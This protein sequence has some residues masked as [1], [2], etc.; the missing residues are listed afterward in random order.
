MKQVFLLV[1]SAFAATSLGAAEVVL[2][3]PET[4]WRTFLVVGP[5]V[6]WQN[7]DQN[8]WPSKGGG[9]LRW[10]RPGLNN[11]PLDPATADLD[12]AGFSPRPSADWVRPDADVSAWTRYLLSDL[13]GALGFYGWSEAS[14]QPA[15]LCLRTRFG[16]A[17]PAKAADLEVTVT[18]LGGAVVYVNGREVGRGFM[19]EGTLH[20]LTPATDLPIESYTLADGKTPLNP[21][22]HVQTEKARFEKRIRRFRLRV[23]PA[24]LVKGRNVLAVG[25]HRAAVAGPQKDSRFEDLTHLSVHEVQLTSASGA[26]VIPYDQATAGTWAWSANPEQQV[27]D[28]P[29]KMPF[30]RGAVRNQPVRGIPHGNPFDPVL[31]IRMAVPRNGVGSGQTVLTDKAGLRGVAARMG[32]LKGPQGEL[33]ADA[34][35]IRYAV[36]TP[37]MHFCDRLTSSPPEGAKTVPVWT[38]VHVH[39]PDSVAGYYKVKPWSAEH[40]RLMEPAFRMVGQLGN[41]VL[42]V[43]VI[44]GNMSPPQLNNRP[45]VKLAEWQ[46]LVRWVKQGDSLTPEFSLL[47]KYLEAYLEHCPPPKAISFYVWD[48]R[49]IKRPIA[50]HGVLGHGKAV[51]T[52]ADN[53]GDASLRVLQWDPRTDTSTPIP[54]PEFEDEGADAFWRPL[55]DGLREAV[56]NRGWSPRVITLGLGG[57]VRPSPTSGE[58][59]RQWAPYA[60]WNLLSHF[61]GDPG[62]KDGKMVVTG[63]LE[64]GLME[65]P[66]PRH[67]RTTEALER[68]M[69]TPTEFLNLT[70][71]RWSWQERSPPFAFRHLPL[72]GD[73]GHLGL[74]FWLKVPES[75]QNSSYFGG[76]DS[77]T[78][79]GPKGPEPTVRFQMLR[80]GLQDMELRLAII[81]S[82]SN[83]PADRRQT[84]RALLDEHL[85]RGNWARQLLGQFELQY[86]WRAYAAQVQ[87]AAAELACAAAEADW[88]GPPPIASTAPGPTP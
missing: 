27:C 46:P 13:T 5:T 44:L 43:P 65:E 37:D 79:P 47:E 74:D 29:K 31:P 72:D 85:R 87:A 63:N 86:D 6:R 30:E 16:I 4:P 70:T 80:E 69:A 81:R 2:V 39:S 76:T 67:P 9:Q 7:G 19:P 24:P 21:Q 78:A 64:V 22:I 36:Q 18:C 12:K 49:S 82:L 57:D 58:L 84:Y 42:R 20:P 17:D 14:L 41:D 61:S 75:P 83:V 56:V 26:G 3:G 38:I 8:V 54:A 33:P 73:L 62:P 40:F 66:Y 88:K 71:L 53:L 45:N 35:E 1:L 10:G 60:R 48:A 55:F 59:L 15:L 11:P 25:L 68:V 51:G 77:L 32:P 52:R 50:S 23:S 34:V 28:T